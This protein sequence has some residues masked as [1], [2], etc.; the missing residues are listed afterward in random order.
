MK[1][2]MF[3]RIASVLTLVHSI[4]HTI[5][6]VFGDPL[7][8]IM[9][10]TWVTMK[11]NEFPILGVTRSYFQFYRG[12]GLGVTV[13]MTA[14]AIVFWQLGTLA[15]TEALRLRPVVAT[16]LVAYLA[17]AVN[18]YSYIFLAPLIEEILIAACLGLA[19]ATAK[20]SKS[21][22]TGQ[23]ATGRA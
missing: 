21:A 3:L 15:Q 7:P 17:L 20:A 14:E 4:M 23:L 16:F 8:G 22:N 12:L 13:L 6:G 9:A 11:T 18:S 5:G 1:P 19:I 10:S 2:A